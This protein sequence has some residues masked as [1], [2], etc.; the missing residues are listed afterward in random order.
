MGVNSKHH[1]TCKMHRTYSNPNTLLFLHVNPYKRQ[2]TAVAPRV[3]VV[4]DRPE[5]RSPELET[6]LLPDLGPN[7]VEPESSAATM[8][9]IW[10]KLV[11]QFFHRLWTKCLFPLRTPRLFLT[12]G[13][14]K[15]LEN[16]KSIAIGPILFKDCALTRLKV[17]TNAYRTIGH[18]ADTNWLSHHWLLLYLTIVTMV[19]AVIFY[20]IH[21]L[22]STHLAKNNLQ[23]SENNNFIKNFQ[24]NL[25]KLM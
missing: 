17:S 15:N 4:D 10:S 9:M 8:H 1:K 20:C 19:R 16:S 13:A 2:L 14:L 5:P 23:M 11:K 22:H 25:T 21:T 3:S 6:T 12:C 18:K 7:M 24:L